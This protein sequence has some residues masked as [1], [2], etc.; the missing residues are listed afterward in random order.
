MHVLKNYNF[1]STSELQIFKEK[2]A[3][4]LRQKNCMCKDMDTN[5]IEEMIW[6]TTYVH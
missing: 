1:L 6:L 4:T 3:N 2:M 5:S